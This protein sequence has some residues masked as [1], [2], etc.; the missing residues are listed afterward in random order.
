[1]NDYIIE[2]S[3]RLIKRY[4]T[5]DPFEIAS[6]MNI[7]ILFMDLGNLKGFYKRDGHNRFIVINEGISEPL[8]KIVCAHELG[9]D[10]LHRH[11]SKSQTLQEFAIY[12]MKSK[13]EYEANVFA[14]ELLLSESDILDSFEQGFTFSETVKLLHTDP[15]LLAIRLMTM[16]HIKRH[17]EIPLNI[18]SDFLKKD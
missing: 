17:F 15:Q 18:Q 4:A 6:N 14:A 13:P 8:Q 16:K 10:Q 1:L 11:L 5:R 3:T 2:R 12:D 7:E 9:H